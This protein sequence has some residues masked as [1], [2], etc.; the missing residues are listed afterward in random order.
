MFSIHEQWM[1]RCIELAKEALAL[2]NPPV[3]ALLIQDNKVIGSAMEMAKTSKRI[4]DHA[5]LLAIENAVTNGYKSQL[6]TATLYTTHEPCVMCSYAIRTYAIPNL[7]YGISVPHIGG[8]TSTFSILK[9]TSVPK[10]GK[11]PIVTTDICKDACIAL[12]Q[13]FETRSG[14]I[15]L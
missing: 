12:N 5:E 7:V 2:G 14:R 1:K 3:G 9:S 10:W 8:H 6:S 4:S 15:D 11:A 13:S